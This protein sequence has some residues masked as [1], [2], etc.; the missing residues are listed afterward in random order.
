MRI[1]PF[2]LLLLCFVACQREQETT[3]PAANQD[4]K[5]IP[6]ALSHQETATS[7]IIF[8][9]V[10]GGK[11]WQ[12]ISAGL[13]ADLEYG[14]VFAEKGEIFLGTREGLYRGHAGSGAPVWEKANLLN[15]PVT[16]IAHGRSGPY[17]CSYWNGIYQETT[18]GMGIWNPMY[19]SLKDKS[20]RTI[21]ET[22]G[23]AIL[24]GCDSG[25][26]KS[27]DKGKTWKQVFDGGIILDL[28]ASDKV[29]IGGGAKGVLRSTDG[30]DHWDYVF[31][32]N[33]LS[34]KTGLL[35]D[36]LVTIMGTERPF[37]DSQ[38]S[39]KLNANDD[40]TG[41]VRVSADGGNTWQRM[42]SPLFP[43]ANAYDMDE[44]LSEML[45]LYDI[46]QAGEYIFCSFNTGVFRSAD[47]GK[48]WEPVLPVRDNK[49]F[50]FAAS[51]SV[52]YAMLRPGGC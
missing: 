14:A 43:V 26:F 41:R 10:D 8:Q 4:Y 38:D 15:Q 22:P 36:K 51:G 34:K 17:I 33:M 5:A 1:L 13:P 49:I 44:R 20:V 30:G 28:V 3:R 39:V 24:V 48:T 23:G 12:D 16:S 6:V 47:Q 35:N 2:L 21:L 11:T 52:V 9:S 37:K 25:I 40:I 45:D 29:L 42:E 31:N 50:N 7:N 18:P 27:N 46:I 32:E 19:E